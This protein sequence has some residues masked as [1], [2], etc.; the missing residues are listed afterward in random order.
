M[1]HA[2][3][4]A[5][6]DRRLRLTEADRALLRSRRPAPV[7]EQLARRIAK[8]VPAITIGA[9]FAGLVFGWMAHRF[10][11][12]E[13]F[14]ALPWFM[15][16]ASIVGALVARTVFGRRFRP[17]VAAVQERLKTGD[18]R[19]ADVD[20]RLELVEVE[21]A[22]EDDP[23]IA[24]PVLVAADGR[25]FQCPTGLRGM[26]LDARL[27]VFFLD[28]SDAPAAVHPAGGPLRLPLYVLG[29]EPI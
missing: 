19:Q 2:E 28:F 5:D 4:Q 6:L 10:V 20:A 12:S 16:G 22:T 11:E 18:I 29:I 17:L 26:T 8:F 21:K 7:H 13:E 25:R 9:A 15:V 24:M 1:T 27:R 14:Q 23:A 3:L